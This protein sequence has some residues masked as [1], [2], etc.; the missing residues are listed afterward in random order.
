MSE[1]KIIRFIINNWP[2]KPLL[3]ISK[4]LRLPGFEGLPLYDV[5]EFFFTRLNEGELQ[6]RARSLAFSFFLALFPTIIFIFT[7]IPYIP[8]ESFPE[9]LLSL[10]RDFLPANTFDSARETIEDI[11]LHQRGGLLSFGFLFA[12]FISADGIMAL[13]TWFNKSYHGKEQRSAWKFRMMAIGLTITLALLVFL[14]VGL[15]VTTEFI[16]YYLEEKQI[17][18]N[19]MQLVLLSLGKWIILLALCF[20]AISLLYYY[21][22]SKHDKLKFISA[23]SSLATLLIVLTSLGFNYFITNFGQY[24]KVYG[25]IG[26]LI[27]ILVWLYINSFVLLVGY[28]LNVSIRKARKITSLPIQ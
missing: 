11:I 28:E 15:I 17:L 25:S 21:G 6:T 23:G 14:A 18:A 22:P 27:V 16:Y 4:H 10:I 1:S 12:L 26:T 13:M 20:S 9:R 19:F 5:G 3:V 2:V 8:I 24:N 7:L